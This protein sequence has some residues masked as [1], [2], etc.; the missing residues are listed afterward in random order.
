[1]ITRSLARCLSCDGTFVLRLGIGPRHQRLIFQ[2]PACEAL[3]R[4]RLDPD[5]RNLTVGWFCE[6]L[7]D[8][9][10]PDGLDEAATASVT[11][12]TDLPVPHPNRARHRLSGSVS[13]LQLAAQSCVLTPKP[14]SER[15]ATTG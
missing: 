4:A 14:G 11:V 10:Y 7:D 12:Y 8:L 6:D 2:C 13:P 3:L 9:G 15:G 1:M 5:S